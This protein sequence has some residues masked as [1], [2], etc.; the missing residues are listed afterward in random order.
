MKRDCL[1]VG[2]IGLGEQSCDNLIPAILSSEYAELYAVCDVK[3]DTLMSVARRFNVKNTFVSSDELVASSGLDVVVIASYPNV[4]YNVTKSAIKKE[5]HVFVEKPP[6]E[7]SEQLN[8]ILN[9]LKKHSSVKVGVGMNFDFTEMS[10]SVRKII[11]DKGFFGELTRVEI[12]HHS[13][14]PREPFWKHDNIVDS[15][16]LAQLIHPLHQILIYGGQVNEFTFRSSLND[17]PLFIDLIL[18]FRNGSTGVLKS[19]SCFPYFE[20]R[21]ELYGSN[22]VIVVID[23]VNRLQIITNKERRNFYKKSPVLGFA[24]SPLSS[25]LKNAGYTNEIDSFFVSILEKKDFRS[26]LKSMTPTYAILDSLSDS[27][28]NKYYAKS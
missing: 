27:L 19:S 20:H 8:E 3:K 22:D 11:G 21:I 18:D 24:N 4:H 6:V 5:L 16:L 2:V 25:S 28:K 23:N 12:T 9:L 1:K 13:S 14:K 7:N 26:D 10:E 17:S 15:F